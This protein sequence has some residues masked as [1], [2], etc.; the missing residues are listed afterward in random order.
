MLNLDHY[1]VFKLADKVYIA[2]SAG[3]SAIAGWGFTGEIGYTILAAALGGVLTALPRIIVALTG[4]RKTS[5]EIMQSE[6]SI[7]AQSLS[8]ERDTV[9]LVRIS[10]HNILSELQKYGYHIDYLE[11]TL[12]Q[13]K[14][15]HD[16]MTRAT[17]EEL[18]RFENKAMEGIIKRGNGK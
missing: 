10:K 6:L 16:K 12:K 17:L 18:T 13:H 9:R 8:D 4:A 3:I 2:I 14:I 5:S 11:E 7:L 1:S 15:A